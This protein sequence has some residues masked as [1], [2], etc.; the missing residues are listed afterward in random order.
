MH[1]NCEVCSMNIDN[2]LK[3]YIINYENISEMKNINGILNKT[4]N[5]E[6]KRLTK[7]GGYVWKAK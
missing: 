6:V 4:E 2:C 1:K 7:R 5:N 3:Y